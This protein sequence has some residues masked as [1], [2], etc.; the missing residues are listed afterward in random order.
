MLLQIRNGLRFLIVFDFGRADAALCAVICNQ[1]ARC[2][3]VAVVGVDIQSGMD[4]QFQLLTNI[5]D[6]TTGTGL[7]HSLVFTC[8]AES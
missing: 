5:A 8:G 6:V 3:G 7:L 4:A 2:H 1:T